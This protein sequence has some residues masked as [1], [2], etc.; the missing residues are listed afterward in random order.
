M[1]IGQQPIEKKVV[2]VDGDNA[3]GEASG[4]AGARGAGLRTLK[5]IIMPNDSY[6]GKRQYERSVVGGLCRVYS[7]VL[8]GSMMVQI[9]D[10]SRGG[11]FLITKWVPKV[12]E[13]INCRVLDAK[14]VAVLSTNARVAWSHDQTYQGRRGFGVQFLEA[15]TEDEEA[16]VRKIPPAHVGDGSSVAGLPLKRRFR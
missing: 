4:N 12:N 13:T 14:G 7:N 15:L 11:A 5:E 16:M 10:I 8:Q 3:F 6:S 2:E 1:T 9:Q